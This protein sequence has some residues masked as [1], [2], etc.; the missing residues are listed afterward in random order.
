MCICVCICVCVCVCVCVQGAYHSLNVQSDGEDREE[1][2]VMVTGEDGE[3]GDGGKA[4]HSEEVRL[5]TCTVQVMEKFLVSSRS[6]PLPFLFYSVFFPFRFQS[7]ES[8]VYL[9]LKCLAA[10]ATGRDGVH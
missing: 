2:E 6:V 7:S 3:E 5:Y 10:L 1:R 9:L 4:H 8:R